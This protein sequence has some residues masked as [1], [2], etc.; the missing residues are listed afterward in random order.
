MRIGR[1]SLNPLARVM[2]TSLVIGSLVAVAVGCSKAPETPAAAEA[3]AAAAPAAPA[4]EAAAVAAAPAA[5]APAP[6][7]VA[8][9]APKPVVKQTAVA[10]KAPP[11]PPVCT[12]CGVVEAVNKVVEEGKATGLG[13]VGGAVVG[14]ALGN[15]AGKGDGKTAMTVVGAVGGALAGNAAEKAIRKSKHFDVVVRMETGET[16][17]FS[18]PEKPAEFPVG[19]HVKVEGD[20]LVAN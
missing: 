13:A 6:A 14:G 18:F 20:Q 12:N 7:P 4:P 15:Q 11:P 2:A 10:P 1:L 9:P 16:R 3:P 5:E 8:A 19:A 17:T